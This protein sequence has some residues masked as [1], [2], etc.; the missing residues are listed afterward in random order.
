MTSQQDKTI[1]QARVAPPAPDPKKEAIARAAE[2][3]IPSAQA[4]PS[5]SPAIVAQEPEKPEEPV[6]QMPRSGAGLVVAGYLIATMAVYLWTSPRVPGYPNGSV[7]DITPE[8][9]SSVIFS[10]LLF[11]P[12]CL[13]LRWTR[14]YGLWQLVL[15]N[16]ILYV[17]VLANQA[18][19]EAA[20]NFGLSTHFGL[21]D[22]V[23]SASR[24]AAVAVIL[25]AFLFLCDL[26]ARVIPRG[27]RSLIPFRVVLGFVFAPLPLGIY[28]VNSLQ[29]PGFWWLILGVTYWY[30][31]L[32]GL[33]LFLL[34]WLLG[35]LGLVETLIAG[36]V[37]GYI[38]A[39]T[40]MVAIGGA[41]EAPV[42]DPTSYITF[43]LYGAAVAG[44]F[45]IIAIWGSPIKKASV[46]R[47]KGTHP[48][49]QKRGG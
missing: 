16:S 28:M 22:I 37:L 41:H 7:V 43:A 32:G 20:E 17:L 27:R 10:S 38:A 2:K 5:G 18:H 21:P 8:T 15:V 34:C 23:D 14:R 35:W 40:P 13:F 3:V 33:P 26:G 29:Q 31:I 47:E 45:W 48:F 11:V 36:T 49:I 39:T 46:K 44:L 4:T 6:R 25:W 12:I 9:L 42:Y 24:G 1:P 30:A 19:R